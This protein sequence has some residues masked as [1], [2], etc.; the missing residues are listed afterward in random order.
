MNQKKQL[1]GRYL[2]GIVCALI[3]IGFDQLT[4]YLAVK[5]LK[6]SDPFVLLPGVFELHYLENFGAAFGMLQGKKVF[7]IL[8]TLVLIV[9]LSYI[10]GQIPGNRRF[11]PIQ[12][13]CILL[14]S[15]AIG[16]F[17]DRVSNDYVTD[18]FYFSLI[19]FP[20]FNVADIYV[21]VSVFLFIV[22]ILFYYKE[23]EL[24]QLTARILPWKKQN[25]QE[26]EHKL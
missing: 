3:L 21:T 8:I 6:G 20:I 26:M 5:N 9:V 12:G 15:G 1:W 13:I 11:L 23:E 18:F 4:K 10:Y 22:L 17:I 14:F 7:F 24:D 2:F 19:N 16:N 25:G